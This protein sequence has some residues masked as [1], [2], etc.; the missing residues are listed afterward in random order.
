MPRL[1][2][3]ALLAAVTV[4]A[5]AAAATAQIVHVWDLRD[6]EQPGQLTIYNPDSGDAEFGTP[7][8]SG[9]IDGDGFDELIVSAMAGDGPDNGRAN[10]G[11]VAVYFS[12]GRF[13]GGVDLAQEP[14]NVVTLWGE[15]NRDIFGIKTEVADVDGDGG[16][17]LLVGAFYADGAAGPDAG[18]LYVIS[19][20]LL[21]RLHETGQ[22][23]D[24]ATRPWPEGVMAFHGPEPRARLGVWMAA[25]DITGDRQTDIVVGAD[26]ARC[27]GAESNL[28]CGQVFVIPGPVSFAADSVDLA[29]P[30]PGTTIIHGVDA[31]DHLGSTIAVGDVDG[32][33]IDDVVA[34]AAAYGTLRNA[35]DRV[36]GAGDGPLNDRPQSGEL[37]VVFGRRDLPAAID[38][39]TEPGDAAVVYGGIGDG[40]SPD[41]LG[42]EIV[43]LD[44]N[45]DG[46]MDI[47]IGAYRAD[48]PDDSRPDA[49]DTYI[50][51]GSPG[52]RGRAIDTADD[53]EDVVVIYGAMEGAISG[54]SIAGGDIHGDGYDDLFIGVPGDDGPL[55]RRLSGG[56]VVIPGGPSLPRVIDLADPSV[57]VVWIQAPDEVD[58]S[59]YWAAAGDIDGDGF[60]DVM[61]NG[62]AGDGPTNRR[63]N[64]GE[65]HAVSGALVAAWLGGVV[66]AVTGEQGATPTQ[67]RLQAVYPNPFNATVAVPFV[68]DREAEVDLA[69]YSLTGQ[70]I[71]TLLSGRHPAGPGLVRW[72]GLDAGGRDAASGV[73]LV[74]LTTGGEQRHRKTLLLR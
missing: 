53:P 1:S 28:E 3:S 70:R 4:A 43:T 9:D 54:D 72:D 6:V 37:W 15:G 61:P 24:L 20:R 34:G 8:R 39:A 64:A 73:Y 23:L 12:P 68:L 62:M 56:I 16:N 63:N 13:E 66:T 69:V 27:H 36:G 74:R 60:V 51:F 59:A 46:I 14:E 30:P 55:G 71:R 10:A 50:V 45:G 58:F 7:V 41:R 49:G 52:L 47:V 48:G 38:L 5:T 67:V 57:P 42:E 2:R 17:D 31:R 22:D 25:G 11:E 44:V 40:N 29:S 33:G 26:M 35:Y 32:D 21:T 18:K 65:A 19:G